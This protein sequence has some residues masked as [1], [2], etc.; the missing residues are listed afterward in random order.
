[1]STPSKMPYHVLAAFGSLSYKVDS[2]EG[3]WVDVDRA[4]GSP[5]ANMGSEAN[6]VAKVLFRYRIECKQWNKNKTATCTATWDQTAYKDPLVDV[7]GQ[8][9]STIAACRDYH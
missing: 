6:N 1:M 9:K 7:Q 4:P 8:G 3:E 2:R 5:E